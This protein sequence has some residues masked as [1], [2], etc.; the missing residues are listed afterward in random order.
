MSSEWTFNPIFNW[1]AVSAVS[2]VEML[3]LG[4]SFLWSAQAALSRIG[5]GKK[6]TLF[7]LRTLVILMLLMASSMLWPCTTTCK[8]VQQIGPDVDGSIVIAIPATVTS[9]NSAVA[10]ADAPYWNPFNWFAIPLV[11]TLVFACWILHNLFSAS[12]TH[13]R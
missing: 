3:V 1:S 8:V 11:P 13:L 6:T 7:V 5:F 9:A 10:A 4:L 2:V 12:R